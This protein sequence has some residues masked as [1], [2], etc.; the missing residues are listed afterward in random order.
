MNE[1]EVK[2]AEDAAFFLA[3]EVVNEYHAF[4]VVQR[5][6]F[7]KNMLYIK[8]DTQWYRITANK[9]I[10]GNKIQQLEDLVR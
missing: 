4:P 10:S 9:V 3:N 5:G 6:D 2:G 1:H 8:L 7:G